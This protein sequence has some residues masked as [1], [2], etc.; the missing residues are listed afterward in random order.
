V[1]LA[2]GGERRPRGDRDLVALAV[3]L[4]LVH[5]VDLDVAE[6]RPGAQVVL[7]HQPVEVDRRRGAGIDLVVG[8]LGQRRDLR[9]EFLQDATRLLERGSLR[10]VDDDL[11]LGLVVEG[12]HLHHDPLHHDERD[13]EN[14][15]DECP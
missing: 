15:G 4:M 9:G 11:E 2:D 10:H 8:H 5:Q 14:D 6:F 13:R 12:Q 7:P 3:P 1:L